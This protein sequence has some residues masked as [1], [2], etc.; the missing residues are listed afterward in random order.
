L[1]SAH[2]RDAHVF[3]SFN[4][5]YP[6]C[7]IWVPINRKVVFVNSAAIL[8]MIGGIRS[9][10]GPSFKVVGSSTSASALVSP[11]SQ[12]RPRVSETHVE[13]GD[14]NSRVTEV[15]MEV[16]AFLALVAESRVHL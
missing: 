1:S 12:T 10:P 7:S 3:V 9:N 8:L 4:L 13:S 16:S 15:R 6:S 14:E 5:R 2:A 11:L